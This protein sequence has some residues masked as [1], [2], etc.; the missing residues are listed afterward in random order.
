MIHK[1]SNYAFIDSQNLNLS[2]RSQSWILDFGKFRRYLKDKYKIT[3]AFL[4][5]G[6]VA[7]NQ[8]LYTSLQKDGYILI[9]KPTLELPNG[10]VKGNVDAELVLHT[11]IEFQNYNKAIIVTG[12]GDFYCL[13]EYL[14]KQNKLLKLMI[15]NRY[16]FSSLF[17][18]LQSYIVFMNELKNK[19]NYKN[20]DN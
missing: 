1:E 16:Q 9:F 6:Y 4:F 19:L 10:R 12:D 20:T 5:I 7:Q 13:I 11:M 18:K 2:I 14:T 15:P 3:K 17:R 8:S